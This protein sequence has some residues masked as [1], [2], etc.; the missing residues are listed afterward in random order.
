MARDMACTLDDDNDGENFDFDLVV[1][2][3]DLIE[4]FKNC[5][6]VEFRRDGRKPWGLDV[7]SLETMR[8]IA[9]H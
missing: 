8:W 4:C 3:N 1:T 5:P 6:D 7:M 9:F 2:W